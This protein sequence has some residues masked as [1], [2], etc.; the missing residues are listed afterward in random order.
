MDATQL[1]VRLIWAALYCCVLCCVLALRFL[2][3]QT[4]VAARV[5]C[6]VPWISHACRTPSFSCQFSFFLFFFSWQ[7]SADAAT[8]C[9]FGVLKNS[10]KRY[11]I[12]VVLGC[13]KIQK[14]I[15]R[16]LRRGLNRRRGS[17]VASILDYRCLDYC[18]LS[19]VRWSREYWHPRKRFPASK[20]MEET[21]A[22]LPCRYIYSTDYWTQK[23]GRLGFPSCG[24]Q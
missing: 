19:S 17:R 3:M 23:S 12:A 4:M 18:S 21:I 10:E 1:Y 20:E 22:N 15:I 8:C 14:S 24:Q 16:L 13:W 7:C 11:S 9:R 2:S 6:D 5:D